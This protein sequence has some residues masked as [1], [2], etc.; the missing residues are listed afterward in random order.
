[1]PKTIWVDGSILQP[2][3]MDTFFGNDAVTGHVHTGTND[4][5]SAP[6]VDLANHVVGILNSIH[7][8]TPGSTT[9]EADF[10]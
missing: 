1:M 10:G 7:L 3:F 4:D 8:I 9:V 6:K 5:G 2:V